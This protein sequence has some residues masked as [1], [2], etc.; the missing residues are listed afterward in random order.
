MSENRA[1]K[2]LN[3]NREQ[4]YTMAF[5]TQMQQIQMLLGLMEPNACEVLFISQNK[6]GAKMKHSD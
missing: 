6:K 1:G 5:L 3:S 4:T 2:E